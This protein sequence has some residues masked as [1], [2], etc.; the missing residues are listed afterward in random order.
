M[1]NGHFGKEWQRDFFEYFKILRDGWTIDESLQK[2]IVTTIF[3]RSSEQQEEFIE[4]FKRLV[5]LTDKK[6]KKQH[7]PDTRKNKPFGIRKGM[8]VQLILEPDPKPNK[9][10]YDMK[11]YFTYNN[12]IYDLEVSRK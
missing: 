11:L 4:S 8:N 9:Y 5:I 1:P 3:Q 7:H 6:Y 10:T 12:I 2:S